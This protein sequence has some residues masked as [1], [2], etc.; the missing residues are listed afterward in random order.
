VV[1]QVWRVHLDTY[2]LMISA[3]VATLK[4]VARIVLESAKKDKP[5]AVSLRFFVCVHHLFF[6]EAGLNVTI[7]HRL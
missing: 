4:K 7:V 2:V 6:K 1:L 5:Q 3:I